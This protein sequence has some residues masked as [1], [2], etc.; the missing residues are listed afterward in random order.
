MFK[1][2]LKQVVCFAVLFVVNVV[3]INEFAKVLKLS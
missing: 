2:I 1:S 3:G